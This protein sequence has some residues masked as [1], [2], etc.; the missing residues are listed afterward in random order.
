M[1]TI[2]TKTGQGRHTAELLGLIEASV[3]TFPSPDEDNF[4]IP[5]F[6]AARIMG[7]I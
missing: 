1:P 7:A 5:G 2:S 3:R 4:G 6:E